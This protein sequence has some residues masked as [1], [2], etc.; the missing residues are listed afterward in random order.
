VFGLRRRA[1]RTLQP[2]NECSMSDLYIF[3]LAIGKAAGM[4]L[5][6]PGILFVYAAETWASANRVPARNQGE[7]WLVWRN[8]FLGKRC[9]SESKIRGQITSGLTLELRRKI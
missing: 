8:M 3:A 4:T 1:G 6:G 9:S 2:G 7:R 5:L